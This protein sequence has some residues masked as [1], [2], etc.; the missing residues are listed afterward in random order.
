MGNTITETFPP[1]ICITSSAVLE[2]LELF[3]SPLDYSYFFS[4]LYVRDNNI[5]LKTY[6][7]CFAY[8]YNSLIIVLYGEIMDRL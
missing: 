5:L 3:S 7:V 1:V 8:P 2:A 4:R 6:F